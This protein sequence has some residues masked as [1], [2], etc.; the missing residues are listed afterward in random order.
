MM[1]KCHLFR[2]N[3]KYIKDDE[4]FLEKK[5]TNRWHHILCQMKK[6]KKIKHSTI[7]IFILVRDEEENKN[8]CLHRHRSQKQLNDNRRSK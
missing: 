3:E 8:E 6:I 4:Y 1:Y 2:L 5:R 7:Y